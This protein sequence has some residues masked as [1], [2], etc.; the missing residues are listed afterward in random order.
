MLVFLLIVLLFD[1]SKSYICTSSN[2][3]LKK[4]YLIDDSLELCIHLV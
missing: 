1:N 4:A 2:N 3:E